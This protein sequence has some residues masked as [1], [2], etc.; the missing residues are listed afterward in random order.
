MFG[1]D[2]IDLTFA[3][4]FIYFVI[5]L[6][7]IAVY[8]VYVY[9][10][11][12]PQIQQ[13]KKFV[14]VSLRTLGLLVL[15]LILFEPIL[16]LSRKLTLEPVN[17]VFIDNS[18]SMTINDG[19]DR[20]SNVKKILDDF[21][22]HSSEDN[23][24]FY[25][26]G[27]SVKEV[28][29][30]SLEFV[31]FKEGVS[32]F[33]DIF[34]SVKNSDDNIAS[35]TLITDGV[36]TSG[37]NPYYNATGIGIPVF[38]IGIGD[39]T[40]RKD[41]EI[42]KVLHNDF[43]YAETPTS[44]IASISN[45]GFANESVTATL[46]EDNKFISQQTIKLSDAGIQNISFDY[47]SKSSGEKKLSIV[48]S[49]LKDEFT[50][51]NNKQVFYVNVLSNKIKVLL[52]ASSPSS[53]LTFIKNS[54][55]RDE[56]LE[57]N[58]I[59][60]ISGNKFLEELNYNAAD[61]ADV[62]FLIGFPSD[63]TPEELINRTFKRISEDKIPYFLT[64]SSG[65]SLNKL[66]RFGNELSFRTTQSIPGIKEVQPVITSEQISNPLFNQGDK[67]LIDNWNN[68]PPVTQPNIIFT[69]RVQSKTLAQIKLNNNIINA[70]LILSKNF[71]GKRSITVLAGDIWKWKLMVA[72]K[73][74]DLFD[75]F[76]VNSVRWL[77][78]NEEQKLVNV[79]TSKKS[80]SQGERVE[81]S[82]QIF[83]E[84][85]NPVS[86]AEIKIRI[87]SDKNNYETEMQS[88]GSGLYEGSMMINETG[89]FKYSAEAFSDNRTLGSDKGNFNI[90]ETDLEMIDPV[91]N[92]PMLSLLSK[93]TDGEFFYPD[94]Y[95]ALFSKFKELNKLS[96]GEKVIT[97]EISLWSNTWMLIAAI[98]LFSLEWFIRKRTGML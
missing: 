46:Y 12:I 35:V 53:D 44:I 74:I 20:I 40:Q 73:G 2:N 27:N 79:R 51:A 72:Q 19:T 63:K 6:A 39:T 16:N 29:G 83:D 80:F 9:R 66:M 88:V 77:K 38:S 1:F 52:L 47:Q 31:D 91:M 70:P 56:N 36:I 49:S 42:K 59:V 67:S 30:D 58:S 11:T 60:Q 78:A 98:L 87:N 22:S 26:F 68:L 89:D 55:K 13:A 65:I 18:R 45:K 97:S 48:L 14:L 95:S 25:T 75:N 96:T 76:I 24:S 17:L 7:L 61:S 84:S 81:F 54:L 5:A 57:V 21:S 3:I 86:D 50:T 90:G 71:S 62:F 69:P 41:V 93:E 85:L 64:L 82:A 4:P 34:N 28:S 32:N 37:D 15:V 43:I 92:Y 8:T 33:E 10:Y 23:I 94:N